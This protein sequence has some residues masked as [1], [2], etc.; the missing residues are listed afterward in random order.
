MGKMSNR[1]KW[2]I[3]VHTVKGELVLSDL[4][5][6]EKQNYNTTSQNNLLECGRDLDG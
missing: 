3:L 5:V 1:P 2:K 4:V 6:E